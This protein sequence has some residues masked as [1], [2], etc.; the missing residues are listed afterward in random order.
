MTTFLLRLRSQTMM[1]TQ[2]VEAGVDGER[3]K[4]EGLVVVMGL[5]MPVMMMSMM[6][7]ITI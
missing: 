7:V 4:V 1:K 6:L 3:R 2:E 5:M